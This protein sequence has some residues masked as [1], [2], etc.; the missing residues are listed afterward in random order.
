MLIERFSDAASGGGGDH[1]NM[2]ALI[3]LVIALLGTLVGT[4]WKGSSTMTKFDLAIRHLKKTDRQHS[5]TASEVP[6]LKARVARCEEELGIG[7]SV[8]I[9]RGSRPDSTEVDDGDEDD[10]DEDDNDSG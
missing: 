6:L 7:N 9:N 2:I 1:D 8:P 5:R 10:D 3:G 4:V